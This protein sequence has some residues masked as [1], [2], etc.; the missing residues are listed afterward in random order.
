[1]YPQKTKKNG[2]MTWKCP[3][4][5]FRSFAP[6]HLI[7]PFCDCP[8]LDSELEVKKGQHLPGLTFKK[9]QT[10]GGVKFTYWGCSAHTC[11]M[12]L[13]E[14]PRVEGMHMFKSGR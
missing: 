13:Y 14:R 8:M 3:N 5:C 9:G 11:S 1:V 6:Q 2:W 4:G 12:F 10:K 7:A